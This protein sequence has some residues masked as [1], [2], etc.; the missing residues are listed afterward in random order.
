VLSV[1]TPFKNS[2]MKK[3]VI[4][5]IVWILMSCALSAQITTMQSRYANL[6]LFSGYFAQQQNTNCNGNWFGA[7]ADLP[8]YRS[9][10][11][12]FNFG[13]WGLYSQS[14]WKDNTTSYKSISDDF[15]LGLN[16]GYYN[17]NFTWTHSLFTGIAIGY[18][19]SSEEVNIETKKNNYQSVQN[20]GMA[21][22]NFNINLLKQT[23]LYPN[24]FPRM[25]LVFNGQKVCETDK[26]ELLNNKLTKID[27]S[28]IW[29]KGMY[30]ILF[31]QSVCDIPLGYQQSV[32]L[33]PKVGYQFGNY[34]GPNYNA[35]LVEFALKKQYQDD[36]F[37]ISVMQKYYQPE[38]KG[39]HSKGYFFLMANL[40][41]IQ[42]FKSNQY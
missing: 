8:L 2:M 27:E 30:E 37:S 10:M 19:H 5:V 20:D 28:K 7:Y 38:I 12:T 24:L 17:Q 21:T 29:N 36:F 22:F 31:K 16:T 9:P 23:G 13:L 32:F 35:W 40:N 6:V 14:T 33:Q 3:I 1:K 15:C 18:R 34:T 39:N 11:E 42:I 25:Q 41:I 4:L 26:E